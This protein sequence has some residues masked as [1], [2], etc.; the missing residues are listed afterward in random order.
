MISESISVRL[1]KKLAKDSLKTLYEERELDS[2]I[3]ILFEHYLGFSR[4]EYIIMTDILV[5][6]KVTQKIKEAIRKLKC[7]IPIQYIIG[8]AHFY[9]LNFLVD[10]NVLIPR[11]ETEE[12]VHWIINDFSAQEKK[13]NKHN[14]IDIGT[15]SGCIAI[16]LKKNL[17]FADVTAIDISEKALNVAKK[18][19]DL[20]HT[21]I[22]FINHN[23]LLKKTYNSFGQ[24]DIIVSN[25]PYIEEKD[26]P[27]I[28]KNVLNYEPHQALF[29]PD[30][31]P[32]IYYKAIIDFS[33]IKLK[34]E[35]KVYFEINEKFG[36]E[37]I[38]V[39]NDKG[40]SNIILKKDLNNK[41]RMISASK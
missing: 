24:Y 38:N 1:L 8:E 31:D 22:K 29:V 13:Q 27:I 7:S 5:D 34:K 18:N 3:Y 39:L 2:I 15:G 33:L 41:D 28:N 12:L 32:L 30:N 19:A 25:P 36:K 20:H 23:I 4:K 37:V 6:A 40:F 11:K 9:E 10:N 14:I 21:S 17:D 16:V 35:G 26:K